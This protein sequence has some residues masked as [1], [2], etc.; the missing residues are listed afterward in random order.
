MQLDACHVCLVR[1][2]RT[3]G[4]LAVR[5]HQA[6]LFVTIL[7]QSELSARVLRV[8]GS[9]AGRFSGLLY[10]NRVH[11]LPDY[12]L[13]PFSTHGTGSLRVQHTPEALL[14]THGHDRSSQCMS[15]MHVVLSGKGSTIA[16]A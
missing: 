16:A 5:R 6:S 3:W 11:R 1:L 10:Q 4:T 14:A 8:R 9:A 15:A 7:S 2:L 13:A 12:V